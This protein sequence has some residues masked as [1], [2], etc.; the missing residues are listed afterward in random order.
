M[1]Q[2]HR[3]APKNP[4]TQ[5][6]RTFGGLLSALVTARPLLTHANNTAAH[7]SALNT[8]ETAPNQAKGAEQGMD[9]SGM[10][11]SGA[12]DMRSKKKKAKKLFVRNV[13]CCLGSCFE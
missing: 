1:F 7:I 11:P 8:S 10:I 2:T 13:N 9:G 3:P 12:E 4:N 6:W 5:S